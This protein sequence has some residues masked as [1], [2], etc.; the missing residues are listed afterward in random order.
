MYLLIAASSCTHDCEADTDRH[1]CVFNCHSNYIFSI[2]QV[3]IYRADWTL[4]LSIAVIT[5]NLVYIAVLVGK[6]QAYEPLVILEH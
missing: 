3:D 4:L 1:L 5:L 2:F 6:F